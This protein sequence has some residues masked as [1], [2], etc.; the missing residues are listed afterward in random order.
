MEL[1]DEYP[2]AGVL[3]IARGMVLKTRPHASA[4]RCTLCNIV[5]TL[6]MRLNAHA[7]MHADHSMEF[8]LL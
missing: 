2:G 7:L 6:S 5:G 3:D 1:V 8:S 4:P